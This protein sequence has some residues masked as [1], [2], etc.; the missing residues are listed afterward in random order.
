MLSA[1]VTV[2]V[3]RSLIDR[4]KRTG[5]IRTFFHGDYA[6][7][8]IPCLM[9]AELLIESDDRTVCSHGQWQKSVMPFR[10]S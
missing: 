1:Q 3:T 9:S 6:T 2:D 5:L 10:H 8:F 4:E 7:A